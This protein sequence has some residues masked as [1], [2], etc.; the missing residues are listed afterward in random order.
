MRTLILLP[1]L[2]LAACGSDPAPAP[3]VNLADNGTPVAATDASR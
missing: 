1:L 2:T 3:A